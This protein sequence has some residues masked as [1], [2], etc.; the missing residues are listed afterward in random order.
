MSI[1]PR[2]SLI[3]ESHRQPPATRDEAIETLRKR[4]PVNQCLL[5]DCRQKILCNSTSHRP[6][7]DAP[8][9]GALA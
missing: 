2:N 7:Q 6:S 3:L 8:I 5:A 1:L 9:H 4:A